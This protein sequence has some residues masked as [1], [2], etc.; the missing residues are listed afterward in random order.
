M[1]ILAAGVAHLS[2]P[3]PGADLAAF[4]WARAGSCNLRAVRRCEV[5]R[6]RPDVLGR[7]CQEAGLTG[8]LNSDARPLRRWPWLFHSATP[9]KQNFCWCTAGLENLRPI[10][11]GRC[12]LGAAVFTGLA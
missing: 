4:G 2:P 11:A 7:G 9:M 12:V 8:L 3:N 1:G 5:G 6:G 10:H